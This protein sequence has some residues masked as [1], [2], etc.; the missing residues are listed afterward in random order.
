MVD[1][2][3][4]GL[5]ADFRKR[6][7]IDRHSSVLSQLS[8][9]RRRGLSDPSRLD[10]DLWNIFKTLAQ[11]DPGDWVPNILSLA[12]IKTK[13]DPRELEHGIRVSL[14]KRI[15]PPAER[16]EW[17]KRKALRGELRPVV[18]RM[19][20]GRV[21]PLSQLQAQLKAR[22]RRRLPL[23]EPIEADVVIK[24]RGMVLFVQCPTGK[25]GP[26]TP[27]ATDAN[28]T[29]LLRLIDAGLAYAEAKARAHRHP[30]SF[31]LAIFPFGEE[32]VRRW[33]RS[34]RHLRAS[35]ARLKKMLPHLSRPFD[36]TA[37]SRGLGFAPWSVMDKFLRDLQDELTDEFE[38]TLL[39]RVLPRR[40]SFREKAA[41]QT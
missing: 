35:P 30:V 8:M 40:K 28:R 25:D 2:A 10:A 31:A 13:V 29:A 18:G 32:A 27:T 7:F 14:W 11:L 4:P 17:L 6:L 41:T 38:A 37:V 22:A 3:T 23:E 34:V 21:V 24:S 39:R 5:S 26:D 16:L 1:P 15:K 19:R 12:R 20:K 9:R 36:A 33:E